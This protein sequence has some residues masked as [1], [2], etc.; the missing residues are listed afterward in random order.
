MKRNSATPSYL[1]IGRFR[2]R[3][4]KRRALRMALGFG[5]LIRGL[6]PPAGPILLPAALTLLSMDIPKLRRLRRRMLLRF[7]RSR[8]RY[9]RT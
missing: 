1:T 7:R 5:L 9:G 3:V 2:I 6:L 8:P 4:P